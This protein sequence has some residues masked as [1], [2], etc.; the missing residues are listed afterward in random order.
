MTFCFFSRVKLMLSTESTSTPLPGSTLHHH[1]SRDC[2]P[3]CLILSDSSS[4]DFVHTPSNIHS[5]GTHHTLTPNH[6]P[7]NARLRSDIV[8]EKLTSSR[9]SSSG[10]NS[11]R[12][13]CNWIQ[14]EEAIPG[15]NFEPKNLLSLFEETTQWIQGCQ[16]PL[17]Q[18]VRGPNI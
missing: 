1:R 14:T 10:K 11:Q 9:H 12:R 17:S 4:R 8:N 2:T 7:V 13:G 5:N 18:F 6:S 3:A 15:P 16:L